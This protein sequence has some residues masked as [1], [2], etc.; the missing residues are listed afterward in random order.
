MNEARFVEVDRYLTEALLD[1]DPVLEAVLQA[2]QAAGLPPI[3]V[4]ATQGKLLQLLVQIRGAS[5]VLEIGTLGG[6]STIWLARGLPQGGRLISLELNPHHGEVARANLERAGCADRV[7]VRIGPALDTLSDLA[8]EGLEPFD[9]VFIDADKSTYPDY[10]T[11][12]LGLCAPGSVIVVDN[13]VRGGEVADLAS[14]DPNV[15]G[16]QQMNEAMA[17]APVSATAIQTVGVKGYD[18]F[19]IALVTGSPIQP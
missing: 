16:V 5:R 11:R 9:L 14:T 3:N 13:V 15:R 12:A 7:E 4:S 17:S 8:A 10:F 1:P 2:S 18:G 19:A 6:Y